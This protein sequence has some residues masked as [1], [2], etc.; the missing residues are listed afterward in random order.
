MRI[1]KDEEYHGLV[2]LWLIAE[3]FTNEEL[4]AVAIAKD[5]GMP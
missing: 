4:H 1:P 5:D 2:L 3:A